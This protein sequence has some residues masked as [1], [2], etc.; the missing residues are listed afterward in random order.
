MIECPQVPPETGGI[1]GTNDGEIINHIIFDKGIDR[2]NGGMYIP[3]T[4]LFNDFIAEWNTNGI[5]FRGIFHT[6][7]SRWP[8]L[9]VDDKIYIVKILDAMPP[10]LK[11]L[12]FPVVFPKQTIKA[13]VAYKKG[14]VINIIDDDIEIVI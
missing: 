2:N 6:H 10:G 8:S 4:K 12:Y 13:Y 14:T 1:M 3:N 5:E 11:Y 7:A 9:S